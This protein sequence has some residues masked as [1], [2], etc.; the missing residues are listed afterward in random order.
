MNKRDARN[1]ILNTQ[2][3]VNKIM[4]FNSE[5]LEVE[6]YVAYFNGDIFDMGTLDNPCN[7]Y[8][9]KDSSKPQAFGTEDCAWSILD[10]F[11]GC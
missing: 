5:G 4:G 3:C 8:I 10:Y 11:A 2:C 7:F 1:H 9:T 6:C